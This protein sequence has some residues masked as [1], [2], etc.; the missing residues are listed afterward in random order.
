MIDYREELQLRKI[1]TIKKE[2]MH[3]C[4][5]FNGCPYV[6]PL[7]IDDERCLIDTFRDAEELEGMITEAFSELLEEDESE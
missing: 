2:L 5:N 4:H 3:L 7:Q 1:K 6:C